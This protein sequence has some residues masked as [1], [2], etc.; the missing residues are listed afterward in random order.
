MTEFGPFG[1]RRRRRDLD[2]PSS[3][4]K[5]TVVNGSFRETQFTEGIAREVRKT[6]SISCEI[7]LSASRI[8]S[9]V[10]IAVLVPS[11]D[12]APNSFR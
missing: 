11:S 3:T 6:H 10:T 9:I 1:D 8:R 5:A 7:C 4:P 12:R 2:R